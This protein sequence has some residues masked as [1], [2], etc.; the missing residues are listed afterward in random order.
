[1]RCAERL[2]VVAPLD[3]SPRPG[4]RA[5]HHRR[6]ADIRCRPRL[7][8]SEGPRLPHE[9][10]TTSLLA[11]HIRERAEVGTRVPGHA[12][13]GAFL[14]DPRGARGEAAQGAILSRQP[15]FRL[16]GEA[17]VL[18]GSPVRLSR[19][20]VVEAIRP[21][22]AGVCGGGA[23]RGH[24]RV[25]SLAVVADRDAPA[26]TWAHLS[27]FRARGQGTTVA[28]LPSIAAASV[29]PMLSAARC[30]GSASRWA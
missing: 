30:I 20:R 15:R 8:Q 3:E 5:G 7:Q 24:I 10:W 9:L 16:R 6:S 26:P 28:L 11:R 29:A 25:A 22:Q 4:P 13:S 12:G 17:E 14:Q 23:I 27:E 18:C 21:G 1:M 2:G 19:C